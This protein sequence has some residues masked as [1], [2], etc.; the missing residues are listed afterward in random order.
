MAGVHEPWISPLWMARHGG[1][2]RNSQARRL[3]PCADFSVYTIY[4]YYSP[5]V[6]PCQKA[7]KDSSVPDATDTRHHNMVIFLLRVFISVPTICTWQ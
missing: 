2:C 3:W 7:E 4:K 1:G 5:Y 6:P